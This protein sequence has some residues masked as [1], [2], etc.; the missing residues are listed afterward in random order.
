MMPKRV[1]L[2]LLTLVTALHG[3]SAATA[4]AFQLP[5]TSSDATTSPQPGQALPECSAN[6]FDTRTETSLPR[7]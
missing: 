3:A 5:D 1:P 2:L 6:A 4:I 7:R